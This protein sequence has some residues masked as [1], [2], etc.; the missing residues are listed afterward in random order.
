M[1]SM[2]GKQPITFRIQHIN[3]RYWK[4]A[5]K[6]KKLKMRQHCKGEARSLDTVHEY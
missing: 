3:D 5:K 2:Q 6:K 1:A 4:K